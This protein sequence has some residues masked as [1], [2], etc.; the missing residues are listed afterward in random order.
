[1]PDIYGTK[2]RK[3]EFDGLGIMADVRFYGGPS[4]HIFDTAKFA[5]GSLI[6]EKCFLGKLPSRCSILPQSV[7]HFGAFG[8][9]CTLNIGDANDE[10]GLATLVAVAAGGNTPLLEAVA[11]ELIVKPLWE[12]L[13]YAADPDRNIDLYASIAGANVSTATA[14]LTWS[15]LFGRG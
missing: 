13:G 9:S 7:V 3:H 6:G 4:A 1:M 10:D 11:A 14:W 5:N 15:I 2:G 8:T 12:L